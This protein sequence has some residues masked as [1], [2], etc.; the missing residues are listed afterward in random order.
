MKDNF[1]DKSAQLELFKFLPDQTHSQ[2]LTV[3]ENETPPHNPTA[4]LTLMVSYS[5]AADWKSY[6]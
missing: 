2:S 3:L 5:S 4:R 6:N 1:R